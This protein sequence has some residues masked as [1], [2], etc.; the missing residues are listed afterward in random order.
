[1]LN[2]GEVQVATPRVVQGPEVC[3]AKSYSAADLTLV[4][5]PHL[6]PSRMLGIS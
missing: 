5:Q 1:M 4:V 3:N 2:S 6:I